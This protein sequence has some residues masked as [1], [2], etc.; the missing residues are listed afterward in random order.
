MTDRSDADAIA[1]DNHPALPPSNVTDAQLEAEWVRRADP[2]AAR[3]AQ[4]TGYYLA[5]VLVAVIGV[6]LCAV[7]LALTYRL[8]AWIL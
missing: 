8:I 4:R 2:P 6:L 5:F 3:L 1:G 7:L